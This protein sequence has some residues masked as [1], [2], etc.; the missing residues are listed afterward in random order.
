MSWIRSTADGGFAIES[1]SIEAG[2]KKNLKKIVGTTTQEE[3]YPGCLSISA[4]VP[5]STPPAPSASSIG[6]IVD[7]APPW[8]K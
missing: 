2:C 5:I 1:V 3:K 7:V 8:P 6:M 4:V